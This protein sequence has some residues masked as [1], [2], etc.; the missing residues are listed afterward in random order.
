MK[1]SGFILGWFATLFVFNLVVHNAAV[2]NHPV[3]ERSLFS[4]EYMTSP[5]EIIASVL[6]VIFI[7]SRTRKPGS[8]PEAAKP[9]IQDK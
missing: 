3:I 4:L 5:I 2:G 8:N 1:R 7:V 6:A 9:I